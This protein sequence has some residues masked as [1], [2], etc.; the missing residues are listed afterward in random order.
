MVLVS[1]VGVAMLQHGSENPRAV[2]RILSSSLN[3]PSAPEKPALVHVF[4]DMR[5]PLVLLLAALVTATAQAQEL[6]NI[7][8]EI[9]VTTG[10]EVEPCPPRLIPDD[11]KA[12]QHRCGRLT[13]YTALETA[14]EV[15]QKTIDLVIDA[16]PGTQTL[17][18]KSGSDVTTR[19]LSAE[20]QLL[21]IGI[22]HPLGG[23]TWYRLALVWWR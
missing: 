23:E 6:P 4:L 9:L 19:S 7:V 18:W 2:S 22:F 5:R 11:G 3:S 21:T 13:A 14:I 16:T 15:L 20:G 8:Q 10:A 12:Y 1:Y 17:P